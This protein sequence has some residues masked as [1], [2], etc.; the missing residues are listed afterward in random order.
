MMVGL[1]Q[2]AAATGR[3]AR[4]KQ[5]KLRRQG[6]RLRA[7]VRRLRYAARRRRQHSTT[8]MLCG[9]AL[10]ATPMDGRCAMCYWLSDNHHN[11]RQ[12]NDD[13]DDTLLRSK[14]GDKDITLGEWIG[15]ECINLGFVQCALAIA[16]L[17]LERL[18]SHAWLGNDSLK[19]EQDESTLSLHEEDRA[20]A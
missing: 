9:Q 18:R 7:I 4:N 10:G 19:K 16:T 6:R 11:D 13:D 12:T 5:L 15:A 20:H 3:C 8:L 1:C 2:L 14:R 17:S